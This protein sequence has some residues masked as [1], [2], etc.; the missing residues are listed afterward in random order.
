VID[1]NKPGIRRIIMKPLA[2]AKAADVLRSV[3]APMNDYA[4]ELIGHVNTMNQGSSHTASP[5]L[6][7]SKNFAQTGADQ[8]EQISG[9]LH[10]NTRHCADIL[11]ATMDAIIAVDQHHRITLFTHA[12]AELF[13]C[14]TESA[15][16]QALDHFIPPRLRDIVRKHLQ[17]AER[18]RQHWKAAGFIAM[19]TDGEEFPIEGIISPIRFNGHTGYM[20]ILRD[21]SERARAGTAIS[22]LQSRRESSYRSK[23]RKSAFMGVV[24]EATG[25]Q[26]IFKA[27][28]LVAKTDATVLI[29]GET[30]TGKELIARAV[31]D[32]SGRC[33]RALITVNCAALPGELI[34]SELFGHERGAFTGAIS[35]RRGRFELADGG[36]IFLDEVGEL[37]AQAQAKLLRVL[38]EQAFERVGGSRVIKVNVRV[39]AA[40]NRDLAQMVKAGTFR[41]DLFYRLNV[42]PLNVPPLRERRADI[43]LL[44]RHFIDMY[45]R[46]LGKSFQGIAS[47]SMERLNQ[48]NWPGNVRELQNLVERMVI[49]AS[50][51][52]LEIDDAMLAPTTGHAAAPV[53]GSLDKVARDHIERILKDCRGIIEGSRGAAAILGL[54]PSTLRYRMKLLGIDK[55]ARAA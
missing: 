52:L 25:M 51:P 15:M 47:I 45:A 16:G 1:R 22:S 13:R 50:G 33:D 20:I 27:I 48:Y 9:S 17:G 49:V 36:T 5:Y 40:T 46:K 38:Q 28:Q 21:A 24:G 2:T 43:P 54:K 31:H 37:S 4:A 14:S 12:A 7:A 30:G 10:D 23:S 11:N 44:A 3:A 55:T 42:F 8:S 26:A 18:A 34:E 53:A 6:N 39:I 19:R 41:A 32:A 29:T 35:Q